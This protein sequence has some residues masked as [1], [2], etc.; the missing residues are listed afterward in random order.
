MLSDDER[1]Q[2]WQQFDRLALRWLIQFAVVALI[3]FGLCV[4][5]LCLILLILLAG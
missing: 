2:Q 3:T 1:W 4:A 5:A